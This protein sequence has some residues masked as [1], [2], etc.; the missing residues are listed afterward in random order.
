MYDHQVFT[1]MFIL[2]EGYKAEVTMAL[3][4]NLY[5]KLTSLPQL[6]TEV[7]IDDRLS[8]SI[9]KRLNNAKQ[10][11]YP[12]VIIAGKKVKYPHVRAFG[13]ILGL[14]SLT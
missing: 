12:Y 8:I 3:A 9:G 14:Y 6:E 13:G 4:E 1:G 7:V 2:Q 5:E 10:L 11:G